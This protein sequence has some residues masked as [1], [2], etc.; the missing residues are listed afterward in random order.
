MAGEGKAVPVVDSEFREE[1]GR[2]SPDG[3][4]LTFASNENGRM[5]L[6]AISYPSREE[7]RQLTS[8]GV[9]RYFWRRDGREILFMTPERT[10]NS[11]AVNGDSFDAARLL[12]KSSIPMIAGDAS[13]DGTRIVVAVGQ[14]RETVPIT[15]VTNWQSGLQ[16]E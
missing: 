8:V 5:E 11:I 15:L 16:R 7:K 4:W 12:F 10:M 9:N 1:D 3:R 13:R 2:F 14:V 6:Y